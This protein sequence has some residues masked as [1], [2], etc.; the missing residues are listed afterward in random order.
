MRCFRRLKRHHAACGG[1]VAL[2]P[3]KLLVMAAALSVAAVVVSVMIATGDLPWGEGRGGR[4]ASIK[5][6]SEINNS[7]TI[8]SS[9]YMRVRCA[10]G[11]EG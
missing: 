10:C 4:S 9:K 3:K 8:T 11:S 1:R 2:P 5:E 6:L 7:T